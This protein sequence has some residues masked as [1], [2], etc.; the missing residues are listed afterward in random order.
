MTVAQ[1]PQE[2]SSDRFHPP[3]SPPL[4][5]SNLRLGD[6]QIEKWLKQWG[7]KGLF[8]G[9]YLKE[10]LD[11]RKRRNCRPATLRGYFTTLTVFLSFLKE[12]GR[13]SLDTIRGMGRLV[14][15]FI[16]G[17]LRRS[18]GGWCGGP[19]FSTLVEITSPDLPHGL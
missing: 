12:S 3:E 6:G 14:L 9:P 2:E 17:H 7:D 4:V 18:Q 11:D 13:T 5:G 19:G 8:G 15:A 10:Y 1:V 16:L